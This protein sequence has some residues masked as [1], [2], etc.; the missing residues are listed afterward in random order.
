MTGEGDPD[1]LYGTGAP[2]SGL[3]LHPGDGGGGLEEELPL[4]IAGAQ[5]RR[6]AWLGNQ[7]YGRW[8]PSGVAPEKSNTFSVGVKA[9]KLPR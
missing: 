3:H 1:V 4:S 6:R 5:A 9:A 2:T 8:R 7:R